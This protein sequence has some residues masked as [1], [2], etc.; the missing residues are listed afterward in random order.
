MARNGVGLYTRVAGPYSSGTTI[1]SAS[2]NSE[3]DDMASALSDSLTANGSKQ[4]L[5]NQNAGGFTVTGLRAAAANGE[6][7]RYDEFTALSSVYQPLDSDL[8]ALAAN[9]TNGL[10]A[11][12]G[13]GTG[14]ARSIAAPAAGITI[15]NGDG[16]AGNPTLAL[17]NDLAQ[18]EA[19]AGNGFAARIAADSWAQRTMTAGTGVTVTNGDGVA[20]N[21]TFAIGQAV[22][23]GSTVQF[24]AI[25]LGH[26]T[27]TTISR[28]SAGVIA[29]EGNTVSMLGTAQTF[30]QDQVI[31]K[32]NGRLTVSN[33]SGTAASV[34][35]GADS[36][37][38]WIGS[39]TNCELGFYTNNT[40]KGLIT[41][42]GVLQMGANAPQFP[43][44]FAVRV[45][46][47]N[48]IEWGHTSA[49]GY[50]CTI[51]AEASGYPFI[52]L[53]CEYGTTANTYR[54]RGV[55]GSLIRS[56]IGGGFV[57]SKIATA[58]A[59]NQSPTT[60][61][62]LDGSGNAVFQG[63]VTGSSDARLKRD[64]T[65]IE[66]AL[67]RVLRI[68]GVSFTWKDGEAGVGVIAQEVQVAFPELV[69][70]DADGMLSVAYGNL[71]GPLIEAVRILSER[72]AALE[73]RP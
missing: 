61:A 67:A 16:V 26:A 42:G 23:T 37:A 1:A 52:G 27:D 33:T 11:R 49:A 29:V 35:M 50:G 40:K 47:G 24:A 64:V 14:A 63:T 48:S 17:A 70:A 38:T 68:R 2:V 41:T 34:V 32:A 60:T 3:L 57:F 4:W 7:V 44:L 10:W 18:L 58:N 15:T 8:T 51:G 12:T 59:D 53:H 55:V 21:P 28:V 19:L 65:V 56:D 25:E 71:V 9:A 46:G 31:S 22:G 36:A 13:A 69:R 6:A 62:T 72:V 5:G 45:A 30:T 43:G 54:T 66:D 39:T 73:A 20:G